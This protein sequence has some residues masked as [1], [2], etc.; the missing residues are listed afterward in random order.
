MSWHHKTNADRRHLCNTS[1]GTPCTKK[2]CWT[3]PACRGSDP[4]CSRA[5][6]N[7]TSPIA[8]LHTKK[9]PK[10]PEELRAW[11]CAGCQKTTC[12]DCGR[13]MPDRA[14]RKKLTIRADE[15]TYTCRQ[16]LTLRVNQE[17]LKQQKCKKNLIARTG[18]RP[19]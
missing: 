19:L 5:R 7:C 10:T 11:R 9:L 2:H 3:C 4:Q 6:E 16:C 18:K 13:A 14:R 8:A 12:T 17:T 1:C 15:S